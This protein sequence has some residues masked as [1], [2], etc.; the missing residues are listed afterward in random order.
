VS[1]LGYGKIYTNLLPIELQAIH[2]VSGLSSVLRSF[3]V[4]ES[5]SSAFAAESIHHHLD[6]LNG[7][8]LPELLVQ[9]PLGGVETQPEHAEALGGL[10]ILAVG[11]VAVSEAAATPGWRGA[12]GRTAVRSGGTGSGGTVA[13]WR[14]ARTGGATVGGGGTASRGGGTGTRTLSTS[15]L[16][17]FGRVGSRTRSPGRR[18]GRSASRWHL[19]LRDLIDTMASE[20]SMEKRSN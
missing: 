12:G 14:G 4:H 19:M 7:A 8:E 3:H 15:T 10:R 1:S 2:G 9:V 17:A 5:E 16:V 18:G 13:G 20:L 11:S 6:L